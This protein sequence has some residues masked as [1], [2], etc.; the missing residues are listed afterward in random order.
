MDEEHQ[1]VSHLKPPLAIEL[2]FKT[3]GLNKKSHRSSILHAFCRGE[4][5]SKEAREHHP[6]GAFSKM[7]PLFLILPSTPA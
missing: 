3:M 5:R 2:L 7:K 4:K 1:G 6:L